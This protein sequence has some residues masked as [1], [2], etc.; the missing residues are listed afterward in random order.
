MGLIG[1]PDDTGVRLNHGTPGAAEGPAAFRK[2]LMRYGSAQPEGMNWPVVYDAGDIQPAFDINE[3][4]DRVTAATSALLDAGLFPV[5][6]GGGHDLTLGYVRAL[7]HRHP[8][9][10]GIYLD[11]HLDVREQP[12]SGMPFRR[13]VEDCGVGRLDVIGLDPFVNDHTHMRWFLGH[14]GRVN[15]LEPD[16]AWPGTDLFFSLDLDAIDASQAPGVS[17]RNPSGMSVATAQR[18]ASEAGRCPRV[19]CFDI[20]E[21]CPPNDESGRTARVAASL[22]L[23]FLSGLSHRQSV[24]A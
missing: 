11:A 18:W 15:A 1:L 17:A 22:F 24:G 12:G 2:A 14:G 6:I 7:A 23:S 3:T 10:G 9:I 20:M 19:R 13:L 5:A 21:L 8:G 4:H 16:G